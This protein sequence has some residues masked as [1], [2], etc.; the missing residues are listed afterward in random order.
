MKKNKISPRRIIRIS[1]EVLTALALL[2]AAVLIIVGLF[3]EDNLLLI[4]IGMGCVVLYFILTIVHRTVFPRKLNP[5]YDPNEGYN[6]G[7]D[8]RYLPYDD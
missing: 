3:M 4:G 6:D 2:A 5:N 1:V 8:Q 7:T